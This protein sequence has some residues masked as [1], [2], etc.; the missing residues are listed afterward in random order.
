MGAII[1]LVVGMVIGVFL[2]IIIIALLI[3]GNEGHNV[4]FDEY[5]PGDMRERDD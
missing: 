5:P 2:G 1:G 3:A 4:R